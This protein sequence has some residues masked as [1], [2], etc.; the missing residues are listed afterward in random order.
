M[1][2]IIV[3]KSEE[4]NRFLQTFEKKTISKQLTSVARVPKI[5]SNGPTVDMMLAKKQ[6]IVNPTV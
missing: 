1:A 5:K 4:I 6:P 3:G 2:L